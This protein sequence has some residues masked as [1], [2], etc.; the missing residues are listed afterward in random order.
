[1]IR[2]DWM[3]D[4]PDVLLWRIIGAWSWQDIASELVASAEFTRG[5]GPYCTLIDFTEA[6]TQPASA[7]GALPLLTPAL[8]GRSHWPVRVLIVGGTPLLETLANIVSEVYR[9]RIDYF[10]SRAEA[11]QALTGDS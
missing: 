11:L 9:L 8:R 5:R 6:E 4:H 1:M 7:A 10:D 3:S 2:F